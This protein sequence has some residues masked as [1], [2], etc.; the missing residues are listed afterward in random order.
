[1]FKEQ[2]LEDYHK[3]ILQEIRKESMSN[4]PVAE[5]CRIVSFM[6][7]S[8]GRGKRR[9][10][11]YVELLVVDDSYAYVVEEHQVLPSKSG[12]H[13]AIDVLANEVLVDEDQENRTTERLLERARNNHKTD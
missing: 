13:I 11:R 5:R 12:K 2:S 4:D 10:E 8:A 9:R 6:G 1:M 3:Q 7:R